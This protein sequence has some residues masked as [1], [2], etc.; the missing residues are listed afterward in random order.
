MFTAAYT[1][2]VPSSGG[3]SIAAGA[4]RCEFGDVWRVRPSDELLVQLR[5]LYGADAVALV[6][7]GREGRRRCTDNLALSLFEV[8]GTLRAFLVLRQGSAVQRLITMNL[9]YLSFEQ[10]I[11]ELEG[12]I[13]ELQLVGSDNRLN[14]SDEIGRLQDK[15]VKLTESIYA[16]LTPFGRCPGGPSSHRP[17]LWITLSAFLMIGMNYTATDTLVT[18]RP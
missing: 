2:W 1:W 16:N 15:S 4:R 5:S 9:N 6:Y 10:S 14:I 7:G 11:A 12:K 17:M 3:L 13:E 18:I 8:N